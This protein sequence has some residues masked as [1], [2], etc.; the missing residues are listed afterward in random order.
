MKFYDSSGDES[1]WSAPF[2]FETSNQ[3]KVPPKRPVLKNPSGEAV[4]VLLPVTLM[5]ESFSD[6]DP[7]Y[8]DFHSQTRWQVASDSNFSKPGLVIDIMSSWSLN[9][10]VLDESVLLPSKKYFWRVKFYNDADEG[11]V[12]SKAFSFE[13]AI[14]SYDI[15]LNGIADDFELHES[16]YEDLN[17]D[18][19]PDVN[20]ISRQYKVMRAPGVFEGRIGLSSK[21]VNVD[22]EYILPVNIDDISD[23][24]YKPKEMLM[25]LIGFK[26]KL[27]NP[28]DDTAAIIIY[29][30]KTVPRGYKWYQY[31]MIKGWHILSG[32]VFSED[33][34]SVT[35]TL[36]DGGDGDSDGLKNG[37]IIDPGGP[38]LVAQSVPPSGHA[39]IGGGGGGCFIA[40]AAYGSMLDK[41]VKILRNFRDRFLI[42]NFCGQI[43]V[44]LYYKYSPAL[45]NF[46]AGHE[47][48]RALTRALLLPLVFLCLAALK[49]G[50]FFF[51]IITVI[52]VAG[53][54]GLA[55]IFSKRRFRAISF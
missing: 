3:S 25:G 36:I 45:A 7:A 26:L 30:S 41:H 34:R 14:N 24:K 11:T 49:F 38:G 12:W 31:N 20:Q 22:I 47:G 4:D 55:A 16:S 23:E 13:T 28:N 37:I 51:L 1:E 8:D 42:T 5:T 19:I 27:N 46:I 29:F 39:G 53:T 33:R 48:L 54:F 17:S 35:L 6:D 32:A 10:L 21:S 2:E 15:N 40:T 43:F 18:N 9:E 50:H 44:K 52:L